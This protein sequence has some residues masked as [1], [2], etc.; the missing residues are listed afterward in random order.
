MAIILIMIIPRP[1]L[2]DKIENTSKWVLV[3][4]RRKTGKTF[5]VQQ[6]TDYDDYY[7]VKRDQTIIAEET[8]ET[9]S[10]DTLLEILRRAKETT[11]V[12]DEF[13]RLPEDFLDHLHAMSKEQKL[14]LISSTLHFAKNLLQANSPLLGLAAE[15]PVSLISLANILP[16]LTINDNKQCLELA[17]LLQEPIAIDYVDSTAS[18]ANVLT[19]SL[20]TLPSF[21]GEIFTEE[22]RQF[23]KRYEGILRTIASG[24]ATSGAIADQL[25]SRKLIDR[26]DPSLVQQYL[27]NLQDF[28]I[29]RKVHIFNKNRYRY[30]HVSP[31]L[32]VFYYADEKYNITE[33][34]LG[35]EE[36]QRIIDTL[37]PHI[38]EDAVRTHL[39]ITHGLKETIVETPEYDIDA[40]LL[41]YQQPEH[42]VEI[43]WKKTITPADVTRA[44]DIL[45][46]TS[47]NKKSLFV[48]DKTD[49]PET[50]LDLLDVTDL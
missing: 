26:N 36:L 4:G 31:L 5:L 3:Y 38:V 13:H 41:R 28:G 6:F 43:K 48:P 25:Y 29:L 47:A 11:I 23:S 20:Q 15:T 14:I 10:Y 30:E 35:R 44:E 2:R 24:H 9:I 8:T 18:F 42:A 12:I 21:V 22:E 49:V 33:R 16:K 27:T 34:T 50:D 37:L 1:E 45:G 39:A 32:R 17:L 19:S 7:F 40:L 46:K